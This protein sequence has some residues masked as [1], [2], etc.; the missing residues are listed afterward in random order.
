VAPLGRTN[1]IPPSI[2]GNVTFKDVQALRGKP[3]EPAT[4]SYSHKE[5]TTKHLDLKSE[6]LMVV[7]VKGQAVTA[8]VPATEAN[9][10]L[11]KTPAEK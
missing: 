3:P 2:F 4:F 1:S 7:A 9:L 6:G 10:A 8:V 5:G 11:T